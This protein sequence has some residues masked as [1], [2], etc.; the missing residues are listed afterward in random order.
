[1]EVPKSYEKVESKPPQPLIKEYIDE[2]NIQGLDKPLNEMQPIDQ[3]IISETFE[4][5][6]EIKKQ[7]NLIDKS[8]QFQIMQEKEIDIEKT[9]LIKPKVPLQISKYQKEYIDEVS[10]EGYKKGPN[11]IQSIDQMKILPIPRKNLIIQN[12]DRLDIPRDYDKYQYIIQSNYE[13]KKD[14]QVSVRPIHVFDKETGLERQDIDNFEIAGSPLLQNLELEYINSIEIIERNN[15]NNENMINAPNNWDDLNI[16]YIEDLQISPEN[17]EIIGINQGININNINDFRGN[18]NQGN[19][20]GR[21]NQNNQMSQ[22]GRSAQMNQMNRYYEQD[23]LNIISN[24]TNYS[25]QNTNNRRNIYSNNNNI[26]VNINDSNQLNYNYNMSTSMGRI[27]IRTME[28]QNVDQFEIDGEEREMRRDNL[29]IQ[30]VNSLNV[31]DDVDNMYNDRNININNNRLNQ[32]NQLFIN[33]QNN[34]NNLNN[35]L[36]E[37]QGNQNRNLISSSGNE[38]YYNKN[39][40]K[41][42]YIQDKEKTDII[43]IRHKYGI[44]EIDAEKQRRSWNEINSIQQA[45]KLFIYQKRDSGSHFIG[46]NRS[47]WNENNR[48]QG[49]VN[50][51]VIDENKKKEDNNKENINLISDKNNSGINFNDRNLQDSTR[52]NRNGNINYDSDGLD[53][54]NINNININ[55]SEINMQNQQG[56]KG[57]KVEDKKQIIKEEKRDSKDSKKSK[58]SSNKSVGSNKII[59]QK[60]SPKGQQ[61]NQQQQIIPN[62][63]QGIQIQNIPSSKKGPKDSNIIT[64]S[65][66]QGVNKIQSPPSKI[67]GKSA[68]QQQGGDN[69]NINR[70]LIDLS[71]SK[72]DNIIIPSSSSNINKKSQQQK[73]SGLTYMIEEKSGKKGDSN[74]KN[75]NLSSNADKRSSYQYSMNFPKGKTYERDSNSKYVSQSQPLVPTGKMKKKSKVKK[76]E[77]L[78]EPNQSQNFQ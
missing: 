10:I 21:N 60:Q 56:I 11:K 58:K 74:I 12:I 3:M 51:A 22:G 2:L 28:K 52:P 1:M 27:I 36:N 30:R 34:N 54:N 63:S 24:N 47:S 32:D 62:Q 43:N 57:N 53:I 42:S 73:S 69:K 48:Q 13:E 67:P 77:Y 4:T 76:F 15:N 17:N 9:G 14:V 26:D 37:L 41:G 55:K 25:Y 39:I 6:E 59:I 46:S 71:D 68:M 44:E 61:I 5:K 20:G 49:I 78:R 33:L 16:E 40:N 45:T 65:N 35:N 50:L 19:Q 38:I 31:N 75:I 18:N 64:K 29:Q 23:N 66:Y 7:P 70:V 72:K 8:I